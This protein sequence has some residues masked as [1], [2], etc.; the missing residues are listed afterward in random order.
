MMS[1]QD[2]HEFFSYDEETG[3]FFWC[4]REPHH[5]GSASGNAELRCEQF[6]RRHAGMPCL[7]RL[8]SGSYSELIDGVRYTAHRVAWAMT[9]GYW[10]DRLFHINRD[11]SDNRLRNLSEDHPHARSALDAQSRSGHRSGMEEDYS[12][13]D[14]EI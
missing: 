12:D 9:H 6:N 11:K 14:I 4:E 5:F 10:P 13:W 7:N 3:E 1:P 2:L 8:M